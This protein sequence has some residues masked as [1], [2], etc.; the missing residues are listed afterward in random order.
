MVTDE[1]GIAPALKADISD[2]T[3]GFAS[4]SLSP[5]GSEHMQAQGGCT[6]VRLKIRKVS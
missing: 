1:Q 3:V 4:L 2:P 6:E 5:M